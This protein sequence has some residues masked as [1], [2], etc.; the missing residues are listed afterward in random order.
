MKISIKKNEPARKVAQRLEKEK[1]I[2]NHLI[3]LALTKITGKERRIKHGVYRLK[4]GMAEAKVLEILS[5]GIFEGIKITIP[6]GLTREEIASIL[7]KKGITDSIQFI[8]KTEDKELL[9][10][11]GI[12]FLSFEGFLFPD[13]YIFFEGSNPEDVIIKMVDRFF[14]VYRK[15]GGKKE[16]MDTVVILASIVEEEAYLEEEKPLIAS[17]YWNRIKRGMKLEADV[18]VQYALGKHKEKLTYR[19]LKIDSPYNTYIHPGIPPG[20]ICSPGKKS[21]ES[22]ISCKKTPYLYFVAK[23]DGSH[24]FS[25]S[26]KEH[27]RN[28]KRIKRRKYGI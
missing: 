23:G 8:K 24:I 10:R 19:D 21:L 14:E 13:T 18:T 3:F 17:V 20:P 7:R 16:N 5:K 28:K 9:K 15:I 4:K 6:E 25:R 11:Y 12:P 27:L 22:V 26:L 2:R 1:V